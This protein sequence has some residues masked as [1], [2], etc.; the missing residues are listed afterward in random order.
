MVHIIRSTDPDGDYG[1]TT[2]EIE[3]R[4]PDYSLLQVYIWQ[5]YDYSPKFPRLKE[6]LDFWKREIEGPLRSVRVAHS[7]LV[8]ATDIRYARFEGKIH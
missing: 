5:E 8:R 1:L 3:Y 4:L 6:F 2:A 7:V